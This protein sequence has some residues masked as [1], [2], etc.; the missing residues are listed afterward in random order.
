MN[1][2]FSAV[3]KQSTSVLNICETITG[4]V[5]S[6]LVVV[7]SATSETAK[8]HCVLPDSHAKQLP[9]DIDVSLFKDPGR[10][11]LRMW[12]LFRLSLSVLRREKPDILFF[13]SSYTLPVMLMLRLLRVK[14]RFIYC[15][16][17]WAALRYPDGSLKRR[18]VRWIEGFLG[19]F[20]DVVINISRFDRDYASLA[21][22][23][24][25]QRLIVNAV[26]DIEN[27]S[28]P[29][30]F[31]PDQETINLLFIGR[32]DLQ[33]GL[34]ILL[35]AYIQAHLQRSDIH[36]HVV[37]DS[38][39]GD[40]ELSELMG[41]ARGVTFH[42]WAK[43]AEVQGFCEAADL[44]IVPSRW[45]GFGLVVA[46]SLR[47]GT[48]ALVSDRGALP[49]L[50]EIDQTGYVEKLSVNDFAA[51]LCSLEKHKLVG[52]RPACRASFESDFHADR[53]GNDLGDLFKELAG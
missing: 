6:Y 40:A 24:G 29:A 26:A 4:G 52:M 22:Y 41:K 2:E 15:A 42:G 27:D 47:A 35:R 3:N 38:V 20:S 36:L 8:H 34:D 13:H 30:P 48:P 44:L 21:G 9:A 10:G 31:S 39:R 1:K 16:H 19:G 51:A 18:V 50:I 43:P 37:G 11:L 5:A 23:S 33:K 14:G 45:E 32:F 53:F 46:E 25:D 49:G 7:H 17:G 12:R 28:M